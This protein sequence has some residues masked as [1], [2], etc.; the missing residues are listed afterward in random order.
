[1][2]QYW[3]IR[4]GE[5]RGPYEESDVLEGVE[6]GTVRPNDLLWVEGMREGLPIAEVIANLGAAPPSRPP[7]TL[8]PIAPGAPSPYR[9]PEARVDDLAELT[10]GNIRYAG[11]WVRY[12]AVGLDTLIILAIA[13]AI[14]LA[15]GVVAALLGAA[16]RAGDLWPNVLGML[17][18]L[19]Y[20]ATLESG[21]R[22]ATY[23]KRAFHL[24]VLAAR[25][26]T[27]ISFL[28]A[29]ARWAGRFLS[30]FLFMIGYLMQP[31]TPRKRALHD[32]IA[33]T[34]VVAQAEHS[35]TLLGIMLFLF[36]GVPAIVGA[37][38][39]AGVVTLGR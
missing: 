35:R 13:L 29:L 22:C 26:L 6:L 16:P 28:R 27:R 5:R 37:L 15:I 3:V 24:Q 36:I 19:L 7:L 1:M 8:Q 20:F 18:S 11:F 14:G 34:V 32:F 12:A 10:L 30:T 9:P 17:L 33:G 31:F 4:G 2:T 25:D 23:G 21:P 38:I 39:G